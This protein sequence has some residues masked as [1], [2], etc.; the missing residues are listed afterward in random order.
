MG[1]GA[2]LEV[3][4]PNQGLGAVEEL[5]LSQLGARVAGALSPGG[6]GSLSFAATTI[7]AT[8]NLFSR[9]PARQALEAHRVPPSVSAGSYSVGG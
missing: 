6:P 2:L 3:T 7:K 9:L 8:K 5:M 1:R 4:S